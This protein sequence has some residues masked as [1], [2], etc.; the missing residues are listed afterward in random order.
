MAQG[1]NEGTGLDQLEEIKWW[2]SHGARNTDDNDVILIVFWFHCF[3][4]STY[5][6]YLSE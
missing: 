5:A 2:Q 1:P 4:Y 3:S 6:V